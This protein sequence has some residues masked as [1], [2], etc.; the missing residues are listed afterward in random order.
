MEEKK[1]KII[2]KLIKGEPI[3]KREFDFLRDNPEKFKCIG[4]VKRPV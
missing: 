2:E 3:S 1:K 4:F